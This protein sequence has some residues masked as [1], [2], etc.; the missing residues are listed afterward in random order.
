MTRISKAMRPFWET[1]AMHN[2]SFERDNDIVTIKKE[3][4]HFSYIR[5]NKDDE[6]AVIIMAVLAEHFRIMH[7]IESFPK[8]QQ[9]MS[10]VQAVWYW[11]MTGDNFKKQ[12]VLCELLEHCL[13]NANT[14]RGYNAFNFGGELS[15]YSD[16][17]VAEAIQR[18]QC[19]MTFGERW[20][21]A[22]DWAEAHNYTTI[23]SAF[24][25]ADNIDK[26][27]ATNA[28]MVTAHDNIVTAF[29]EI[30]KKKAT[31]QEK[32]NAIDYANN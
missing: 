26:D 6:E 14:W 13:A 27:K 29:W 22:A 31:R 17:I 18:G 20:D 21:R 4:K 32:I 30:F 24:R 5:V 28:E 8:Y 25:M 2:I 15:G 16:D 9:R 12:L 7:L 19:F 23:A 11:L 3:R 10:K 1:L